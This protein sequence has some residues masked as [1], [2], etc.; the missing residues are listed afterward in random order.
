MG[1][2]PSEIMVAAGKLSLLIVAH[3]EEQRIG[4]CIASGKAADEVVVLLDRST[5]AT[6]DIATGM[7]A[8]TVSGAWPD[9]GERRSA[10]IA[11][12]TGDW[13]L[14]L[15]SDERISPRLAAELRAAIGARDVDY[16]LIPFRNHVGGRWIEHGWGAYNGVGAKAAL[17]RHDAKR[18]LGGTVHPE[19]RLEGRKAW[20]KGHIDHFID[21]DLSDMYDRLNRNTSAAAAD[22]LAQGKIPRA[23]TTFRRFFSRFLK[24]YWQRKGYREGW[25]GIA[26]AFFSGLYPVL[27]HL[28]ILERMENS[29]DGKKTG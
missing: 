16:Y 23:R 5:D 13:I 7:G 18:W 17:F 15:D 14:E 26:L 4:D 24:S 25:R 19:I 20:L 29:P 10:G 9:E 1:L 11:A 12:C 3:N 8:R 21:A 27:T 22:A 2:D 6:G 28:K